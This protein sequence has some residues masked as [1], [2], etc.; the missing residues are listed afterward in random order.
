[1]GRKL[2]GLDQQEAWA[3]RHFISPGM[4]ILLDRH[5]ITAKLFRKL[6]VTDAIKVEETS[7]GVFNQEDVFR[8]IYG[9]SSSLS[10]EKDAKNVPT[11]PGTKGITFP[12]ELMIPPGSFV[13]FSDQY[14]STNESTF[15]YT[16][17]DRVSATDYLVITH[18]LP[19]TGE[20]RSKRVFFVEYARSVGVTIQLYKQLVLTPQLDLPD[21]AEDY[22]NG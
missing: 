14:H 11:V 1:M 20:L 9:P 19:V 7:S 12:V 8:E 15:A 13:P 5:K 22:I 17:D 6:E 21:G 18:N 3:Q 16:K 2:R 4:E 10:V